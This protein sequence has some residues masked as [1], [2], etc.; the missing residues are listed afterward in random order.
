MRYD[1]EFAD[2]II[3]FGPEKIIK[4][5]IAHTLIECR[6]EMDKAGAHKAVMVDA[7]AIMRRGL[8]K[9]KDL[10]VIELSEIMKALFRWYEHHLEFHHQIEHR[11][12]VDEQTQ[13]IK[14]SA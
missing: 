1:L 3:R 12:E 13:E 7:P 14:L 11:L 5:I 6:G 2:Q 9:Y 10:G 4:A 8:A